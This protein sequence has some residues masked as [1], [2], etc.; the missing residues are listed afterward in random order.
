MI[1]KGS[2]SGG[3]R[4]YQTTFHDILQSKKCQEMGPSKKRCQLGLNWRRSSVV[5]SIFWSF[6]HKKE[7]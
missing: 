6:D 1:P 7:G 4:K 5:V 3:K 2:G